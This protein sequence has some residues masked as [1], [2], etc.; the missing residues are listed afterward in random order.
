MNEQS[1]HISY[2]A[3]VKDLAA[4]FKKLREEAGLSQERTAYSAFIS[5]FTYLKFEHGE[6]NPGTPMNPQLHTLIALADV[7]DMSILELLDVD[8][9]EN[10]AY[11]NLYA[12]S[13]D[14]EPPNC[15]SAAF[16]KKLGARMQK[17]R[18]ERDMT[19]EDVARLSGISYRSYSYL[20]NGE[21]RQGTPANPRLSTLIALAN[22]FN[23]TLID[24]LAVDC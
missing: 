2:E 9:D 16:A 4:R 18:W 6:S 1:P 20:E 15:D 24:L 10:D 13:D 12:H 22:A 7:F 14:Y 11:A 21:L 5:P 3:F 17:L 8:G 23:V 19:K